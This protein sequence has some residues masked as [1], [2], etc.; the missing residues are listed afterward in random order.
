MKFSNILKIIH[1]DQNEVFLFICL[2]CFVFALQYR[3]GLPK[4]FY[5]G[6]LRVVYQSKMNP[7]S[8]PKEEKGVEFHDRGIKRFIE[9]NPHS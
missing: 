4:L 9:F 1:C 2:F 7:Y 6:N 3:V 5:S 8:L